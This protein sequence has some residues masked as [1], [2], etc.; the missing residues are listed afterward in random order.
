MKNK[1]R[2]IDK[3]KIIKI[4][5]AVAVVVII[6]LLVWFLYLYPRRVFRENERLLSEAGERYY[7]I[8]STRLPKD[9]G[10]VISVTLDTLIK[11]D[12]LDGLYEAYGNKLCDLNESN[13]KAV[14]RDGKYEYYTYLKC[15]SFESDVDH[16]DLLLHLMVIQI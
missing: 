7:E 16:E 8:N 9:E 4:I 2:S 12:Y 1:K 10:R 13:V 5:V 15:G 3:K 14:N 6:V 11:Q